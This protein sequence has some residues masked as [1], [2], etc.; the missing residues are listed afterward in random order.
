MSQ[1]MNPSPKNKR[2]SI[3]NLLG[4]KYEQHSFFIYEGKCQYEQYRQLSKQ[5]DMNDIREENETHKHVSR[6]LY[7]LDEKDNATNIHS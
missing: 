2:H 4:S 3:L 5:K 7:S 1:Y 6:S